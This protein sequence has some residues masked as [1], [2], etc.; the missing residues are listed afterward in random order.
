M[1]TIVVAKHQAYLDTKNRVWVVTDLFSNIDTNEPEACNLLLVGNEKRVEYVSL[2]LMLAA[3]K[4][5]K[6]KK[7][8]LR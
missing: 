6:F 8:V 1:G 4:E 7:Y 5:G 2:E 3:I